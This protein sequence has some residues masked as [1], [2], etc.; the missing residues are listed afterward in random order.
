MYAPSPCCSIVLWFHKVA[1]VRRKMMSGDW[2]WVRIRVLW[3]A[4]INSVEYSNSAEVI[5]L[6]SCCWELLF[7]IIIWCHLVWKCDIFDGLRRGMEFIFVYHNVISRTTLRIDVRRK[8]AQKF[9]SSQISYWTVKFVHS[10]FQQA[11]INDHCLRSLEHCDRGFESHSRHGC[12][13]TFILC[14]CC[15]YVGNGLATGWSPVRGVLLTVP[16]IK[17][18]KWN[19][20]FHGLETPKTGQEKKN[21][22][23]TTTINTL[24]K[25][26]W[27]I[28]PAQHFSCPTK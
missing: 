26:T 5:C 20:T 16:W 4:S 6:G 22:P 8:K 9:Q 7:H 23:Q 17:K 27:Q 12:I 11:Y 21:K 14:L 25:A 10:E 15:S 2:N 3:K 28:F 13:S 19:K 24:S 18:L 1:R